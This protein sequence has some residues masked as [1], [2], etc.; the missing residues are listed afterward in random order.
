MSDLDEHIYIVYDSWVDAHFWLTAGFRTKCN[1]YTIKHAHIGSLILFLSINKIQDS[2]LL[3]PP[4]VHSTQP[5]QLC[6]CTHLLS[7]DE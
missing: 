7:N 4:K 3:R 2:S 5:D 1:Y 6:S